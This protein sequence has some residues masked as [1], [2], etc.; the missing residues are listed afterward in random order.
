MEPREMRAFHRKSVILALAVSSVA[1]LHA[2]KSP[3]LVQ[4]VKGNIA[5][6][7]AAIREAGEEE[8]SA[9]AEKGLDFL[10]AN[11]ELLSD[12]RDLSALGVVSVL[13]LSS[14]QPQNGV[15]LEK[16]ISVFKKCADTNVR[17]VILDKLPDFAQDEEGRAKVRAL[18]EEFLS[19]DE[20]KS[21]SLIKNSF[22]ALGKI[23][24]QESLAFVFEQYATNEQQNLADDMGQ[25]LVTLMNLYPDES[26]RLISSSEISKISKIFDLVSKSSKITKNYQMDVVETALSQTLI[27]MENQQDFSEE[28]VRFQLRLVEFIAK[29]KWAHATD[30]VA[31]NFSVAKKEYGEN[32][33]S[34]ED[35]IQTIR[36]TAA[37]KSS[38]IS[39]ALSDC[40]AR[41][42]GMVDKESHPSEQIVLALINSLGDLGDKT[43]F[44]NLLYVTYLDYSDEV[45]TAAR[46]AL[47]SLKW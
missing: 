46:V 47:A 17:T 15:I 18:V 37:L 38:K 34:E 24:N 20:N 39:A 26:L 43:A 5:D 45:V 1:F 31:Q 29:E 33:L 12:D 27:T 19:S 36:F 6:K 9:L 14:S 16:L 35:F 44:D 13:S 25:S 30:L 8:K 2:Q 23:G 22:G 11:S 7:T 32:V 21:V 28:N 40:L 41:F 4:F 42:N 10:D 3:L